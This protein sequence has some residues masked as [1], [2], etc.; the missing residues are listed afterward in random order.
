MKLYLPKKSI[1]TEILH[2]ENLTTR[3]VHFEAVKRLNRKCS[4]SIVRLLEDGILFGSPA[5]IGGESH[6]I[7]FKI[8]ATAQNDSIEFSATGKIIVVEL[9]DSGEA[10]TAVK[11]VQFEVT[12]WN[13]VL[14]LFKTRQREIYHLFEALKGASDA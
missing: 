3:M 6:N 12:R 1:R 13:E 11:L 9:A 2:L 10:L 5:Q 14:N 8:R 4:H 7:R